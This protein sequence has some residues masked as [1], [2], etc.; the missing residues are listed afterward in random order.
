VGTR[1]QYLDGAATASPPVQY[2][3]SITLKAAMWPMVQGQQDGCLQATHVTQKGVQK[4]SINETEL[5]KKLLLH[6]DLTKVTRVLIKSY[7]SSQ[8]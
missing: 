2:F 4:P 7:F 5:E 1:V 6:N 8:I 3:F